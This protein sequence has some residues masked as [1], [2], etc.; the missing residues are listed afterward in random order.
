MR[1]HAFLLKFL[2]FCPPHS[3]SMW[4]QKSCC[5]QSTF[6]WKMLLFLSRKIQWN[7]KEKLSNQKLL[8]LCHRILQLQFPTQLLLFLSIHFF[9]L[10]DRIYRMARFPN[11]VFFFQFYWDIIDTQLCLSVTRIA[12]CF[13][14]DT[15]WSEYHNKLQWTCECPSS[16]TDTN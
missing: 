3:S 8:S 12:S 4:T 6:Q 10:R 9:F 5:Q 11:V 1:K 13:D 7:S 2:P 16:H 14:L 15:S